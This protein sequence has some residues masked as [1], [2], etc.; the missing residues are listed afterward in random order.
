[1]YE[2]DVLR[3]LIMPLNIKEWFTYEIFTHWCY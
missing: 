2:N 3:G 1:V